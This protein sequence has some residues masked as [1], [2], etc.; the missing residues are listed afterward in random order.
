MALGLSKGLSQDTDKQ[1][2]NSWNQSSLEFDGSN[3]YIDLAGTI[4]ESLAGTFDVEGSNEVNMSFSAWVK[5]DTMS[6]TGVIFNLRVGTSSDNHIICMYHGSGNNLRFTVKFD[7][8]AE[9]CSDGTLAS[10][11]TGGSFEN[12]G[13]YHIVGTVSHAETQINGTKVDSQNIART[14]DGAVTKLTVG[15]NTSNAALWNGKIDEFAIWDRVI[16]S[17]ERGL[18]YNA[19]AV[20]GSGDASIPFHQH[21]S[22]KDGLIVYLDAEDANNAAKTVNLVEMKKYDL[23]NGVSYSNDVM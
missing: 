1:F 6:S 2:S 8:T 7:G 12:A 11:A 23:V 22:L 3:D 14:L 19:K 9:V 4:T 18:L 16:T 15:S 10:V 5:G 21:P 17:T 13:W 20:D